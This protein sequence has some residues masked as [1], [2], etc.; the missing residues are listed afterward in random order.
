MSPK[1]A[2]R[3]ELVA[4]EIQDLRLI[5]LGE[6]EARATQDN[7]VVVTHL[8][9]VGHGR[10]MVNNAIEIVEDRNRDSANIDKLK[11]RVGTFEGDKPERVKSFFEN[12]IGL[13]DVEISNDEYICWATYYT[14]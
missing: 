10:E 3:A 5:Y 6:I 11:F 13:D 2:S 9:A 4:Q 1:N 14:Y 7:I 12:K 8:D